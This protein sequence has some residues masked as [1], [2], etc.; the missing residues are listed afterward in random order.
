ME[1][2]LSIQK[3]LV[4][5]SDISVFCTYCLFQ[6]FKCIDVPVPAKFKLMNEKHQQLRIKMKNSNLYHYGRSRNM[7]IFYNRNCIMRL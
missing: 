1:F 2:L 6:A 3:C 7:H 5:Q 4:T